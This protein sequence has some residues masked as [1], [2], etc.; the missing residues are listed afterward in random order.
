MR[1]WWKNLSYRKKII[2]NLLVI[3]FWAFG[4][5]A[6]DGY[7]LPTTEMEFRRMERTRLL[8]GSEIVFLSGREDDVFT[9]AAGPEAGKELVIDGVWVVG[10][11]EEVV[12]SANLGKQRP[13]VFAEIPREKEGATLVPLTHMYYI[14]TSSNSYWVDEFPVEGG[15]D[16]TCRYFAPF[17]L[18]DVPEDAYRAELIVTDQYG[19]DHAGRG[20]DLGNGIWLL[21]I[22]DDRGWRNDWYYRDS[23]YVLRLYDANGSLLLNREGG[24]PGIG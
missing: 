13:W 24:M 11:R 18:V 23:P 4:V 20:W 2:L 8:P 3:A 12:V 5:W 1:K 19:E 7:P 9:V 22:E 16:Y 10:L 17:V 15:Y 14:G 6:R 21:G